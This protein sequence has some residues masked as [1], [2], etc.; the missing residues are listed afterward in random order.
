MLGAKEARQIVTDQIQV[1]TD[2]YF[3]ELS[4]KIVA[5][6]EKM[7]YH[8]DC[9]LPDSVVVRSHILER[10]SILDYGVVIMD[11]NSITISW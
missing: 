1:E 2:N 10:L 5:A 8:I 3:K 11:T 9:I 4:E 7:E 6:S